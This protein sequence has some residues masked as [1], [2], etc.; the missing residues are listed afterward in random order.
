ML[1]QYSWAEVQSHIGQTWVQ[2]WVPGKATA[3]GHRCCWRGSDNGWLSTGRGCRARNST[4]A[5]DHHV[6]QRRV[7]RHCKDAIFKTGRE[8][9]TA[10]WNCKKRRRKIGNHCPDSCK[11]KPKR[12]STSVL[13]LALFFDFSMIVCFSHS[14]SG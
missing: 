9:L 5:M 7:K 12:C 3:A 1:F 2:R 4:R 8:M 11:L 13:V 6:L 10:Q 14:R